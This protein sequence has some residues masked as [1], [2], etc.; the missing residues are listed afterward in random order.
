MQSRDNFLVNSLHDITSWG[1]VTD[2]NK[3]Y[4][5]C[6]HTQAQQTVP[7]QISTTVSNSLNTFKCQ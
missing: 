1:T 3:Y 5:G 2:I 6:A 7:E 4:I